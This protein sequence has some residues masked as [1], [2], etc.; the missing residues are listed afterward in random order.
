MA[1]LKLR[2]PPLRSDLLAL[3]CFAVV[4]YC[5]IAGRWQLLALVS[6][7]GGLLAG[8]APSLQ[9]SFAIKWPGGGFLG[10]FRNPDQPPRSSD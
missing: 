6:L 1:H 7:L 3:V 9:G 2:W 4:I 5:L 8:L 10:S